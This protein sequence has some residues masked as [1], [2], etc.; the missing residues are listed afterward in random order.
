[1]RNRKGMIPKFVRDILEFVAKMKSPVKSINRTHRK[2][3]RNERCRCGS[4]LKYKRCHYAY[5]VKHG[6][7]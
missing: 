1:M 5:D 7:R 4:P 3:G 2:V 6:L